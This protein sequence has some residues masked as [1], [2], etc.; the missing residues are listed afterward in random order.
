MAI[1][2]CIALVRPRV[3]I[4]VALLVVIRWECVLILGVTVNREFLLHGDEGIHAKVG[5]AFWDEVRNE[6]LSL[7][8]EDSCLRHRGV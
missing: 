7:F 6:M 1:S 3:D 4:A 5:Q 8:A 2:T